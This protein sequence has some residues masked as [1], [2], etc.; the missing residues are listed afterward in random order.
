GPPYTSGSLPD[1]WVPPEPLGPPYTSGSLPDAWVPPGRLGPP[2]EDIEVCF[3][4]EGW[5][6]KGSFAQADVHR[7]VA[8]VFRTPP[9]RDPALRAPVTVHL[10]LQRPSDRQ[11]SQPMDFQYLPHQGD[12]ECI[13]EKRKRTRETFRALVQHSGLPGPAPPPPHPPHRG[14]HAAPPPPGAAGPAPP[15]R[16]GGAGCGGSPR[17]S[18][19]GAGAAAAAVRGGGGRGRPAPTPRPAPAR[20]RP[21]ADDVIPGSHRP[22]GAGRGRGAGP[23]NWGGGKPVWGGCLPV[24]GRGFPVRGRFPVWGGEP[25]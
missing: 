23:P 13:E 7:Q 6:A 22:I 1:A 9:F 18:P 2:A 19:A 12:L 20:P 25:V 16:G 3:W 15:R 5:E 17:P 14:S 8:I 11:R 4:A 10:Q 21:P 24:W